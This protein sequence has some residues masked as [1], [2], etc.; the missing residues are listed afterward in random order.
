MAKRK[1]KLSR[2]RHPPPVSKFSRV[3]ACSSA[4][5]L[6]PMPLVTV[7]ADSI[8]PSSSSPI[9]ATVVEKM[10]SISSA[11]VVKDTLSLTPEEMF[12]SA[13]PAVARIAPII[14]Y[15]ATSVPVTSPPKSELHWASKFKASLRNL[16]Q[17][18][19][20][21]YLDDDTP[22]VIA[23][24]SVLLKSA[25]MWKGHIMA[26]FHGLC[27]PSSKIFTDLN[28]IWGR[29]G[30]LTVRIISET[31]A[32]IFISSPATRVSSTLSIAPAQSTCAVE[33]P[34]PPPKCLNCGRY[35]HLLSCCPKPLMEKTPF[36]KDIPS[37]SKEVTHP[38]IILQDPQVPQGNIPINEVSREDSTE[39]KAKKIRS[40]SRKRHSCMPFGWD[41]FSPKAKKRLKNIWHNRVRSAVL[42]HPLQRSLLPMLKVF[43]VQ[44][45]G[46][47]MTMFFW[48]VRGLNSHSRQRVI[49]RW[50]PLNNLLIGAS[51]ETRVTESN[52]QYVL[53]A[54]TPGW[55]MDNNYGYS[56]LDIIWLV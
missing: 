15:G 53:A 12:G 46:S 40:R 13:I 29:C 31:A 35:G 48:N 32:L 7:D 36:K 45:F 10:S 2:S 44:L 27:P 55:R 3:L 56:D 26:Q 1:A 43:W 9:S 34:R 47:I 11:V 4:V 6:A 39:A 17:M 21:T 5:T 28:P 30:N 14:E 37:G 41:N 24:P 8:N 52:S 20:P 33:Y 19:P 25:E 51:L 49:R 38:T 18:D 50:I 22:V 16:K 23:P 54:A 42:V